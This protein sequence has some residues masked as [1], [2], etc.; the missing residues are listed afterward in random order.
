MKRFLAITLLIT[1]LISLVACVDDTE[2]KD[3]SSLLDSLKSITLPSITLPSA[4]T[5][6]TTTAPATTAPPSGNSTPDN[7][8]KVDFSA[9]L[10]TLLSNY[11]WNPKSIIPDSLSPQNTSN[12]VNTSSLNLNYS[13][14]VSVSNIPSNGIGEQWNMT[15]ENISESQIF[16]NVLSVV[17]SLS[18]ISVSTFNNYLD[19]NPAETAHYQFE[20]GIYSVTIHCTKTT[21][22]YV[23][24]Y[25]TTLPVLGAQTVQIALSMDL[26]TQEKNVRIQLGED[27]AVAYS[28]NGNK[29]TF[30]IKY[31]GD[32]TD[33]ISRTAYMEIVKNSD[34]TI[35]GHIY[36]YLTISS[37]E[38]ASASDFYITNDY[39][40][41]VGNK[42]NGLVGFDGYICELYS[43]SNGR[44]IGYEVKESLTVSG[45][46][47]VY[48]TLW[49]DLEDIDGIN[50]I[51]HI[52]AT[53]QD[54]EDKIYINGSSSLWKA[55]NYGL[56][57]GLKVASRRFDIEFRTQYFYYYDS[58][59]QKYEKVEQKVPMLFVQ[60]E[61]YSDLV[62]DVKD[63]NN[64]TIS[65]KTSSSA[66][67]KLKSEYAAK[68]DL[69]ATNKDKYSP[70]TIVNFIGKKKSF[71]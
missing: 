57:G 61:V 28:I 44:M 41:V 54:L 6:P 1:L 35:T 25:S 70:A 32:S 3:D 40:T 45:V 58:A 63:T 31:L 5:A 37:I 30:A 34:N 49:F 17:D 26:N 68:I 69:V 39:L 47:V 71:S 62:K 36:E 21:I 7:N 52:P 22:D 42:A 24:E 12:L 53:T 48:N 56:S 9:C 13:N 38:F 10:N 43:I 33:L 14:F 11:K 2:K 23:I 8:G 65:V 15:I 59:N 4:T 16:F 29:Y 51:K 50:T 64:V 60:E 46:S 20:N 66:V 67:S 19:K 27:N 55:K 18:T